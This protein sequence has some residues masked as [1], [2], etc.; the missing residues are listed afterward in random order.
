MSYR[1]ERDIK[2]IP[3]YLVI[4][5]NIAY[6]CNRYAPVAELVDALDLGS[7]NSRCAGSSPVRRT[8]IRTG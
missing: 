3:K 2:E 4:S 8:E 6:L 7:S 5:K 1:L